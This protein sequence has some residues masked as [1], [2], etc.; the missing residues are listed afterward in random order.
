MDEF[1]NIVIQILCDIDTLSS[2]WKT[3][4]YVMSETNDSE[5][6]TSQLFRKVCN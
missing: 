6:N 3:Y 2:Y 4:D 5:N 1:H